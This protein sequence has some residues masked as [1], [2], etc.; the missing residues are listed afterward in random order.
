MPR[1]CFKYFLIFSL[2]AFLFIFALLFIIGP[3]EILNDDD[4]F[5][6]D[7]NV[8]SK[9][10][11]EERENILRQEITEPIILW[12]TPFTGD[13]GIYKT[14]G[15]VKCFFTNNR[16]YKDHN[17]TQ[18]FLFY[19]TDFKPKDLPVP[20]QTHHDW[21]L[22]H[23]ESPKNNYLF[24]HREVMELFNY[25]STFR[26]ESSYPIST[27][28]VDSIKWLEDKQ[29]L[30]P[31]EKKNKFLEELSPIIYT[32][33]DCDVPSGRD[34]YTKL[35]MQ[36][37]NIDSYGTCLHNKDLPQN[38]RDPIEGMEHDEFY[39]L[40]AKYKFSLAME[41]G[42]CPDY[43]TEKLWRPF[44]LG[45]VPIILGSPKVKDFLPSNHSAIVVDDYKTVEELASY[46]KFLNENDDEYV[47][48]LDWKNTGVSNQY[49]KKIVEEREWHVQNDWEKQEINFIEG[50]QCYVCKKLH[51]NVD[52]KKNLKVPINFQATKD[53]YGCPGP[54]SFNGYGQRQDG[55][56]SWDYDYNKSKY[57]AKAIN[58]LV[59]SGKYFTGKDL[60]HL[61][62][63][64][65][66]ELR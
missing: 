14:C 64:I 6:D 60:H 34:Q 1:N 54:V 5:Y 37:I 57:L 23:E 63:Q 52:R 35:L 28:Y 10:K 48:Y 39:K 29:Y 62:K 32:Q 47:K 31:V 26:R 33:S 46:I 30:L 27:Q 22:L 42:L 21:G 58:R 17:K 40:N 59:K 56:A 4:L 13:A 50:F 55:G 16:L 43:M 19:G 20:R 8:E 38:L 2:T 3:S 41:N 44:H 25:T 65:K 66:D 45:S 12:W 9:Q 7:S 11:P 53:H 49:L 15:N 51:E 61:A 36:F 18:A 24:S